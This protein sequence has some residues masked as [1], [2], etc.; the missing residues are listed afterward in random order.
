M[1]RRRSDAVLVS[2]QSRAPYRE[3]IPFAF[4]RRN[5]QGLAEAVYRCTSLPDVP[6]SIRFLTSLVEINPLYSNV[7]KNIGIENLVV[8]VL[9]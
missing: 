7:L 2:T 6:P 9:F 1:I 8:K 4:R 5:A 3:S